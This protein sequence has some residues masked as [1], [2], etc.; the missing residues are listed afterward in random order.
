MARGLGIYGEDKG[1]LRGVPAED[2][3]DDHAQEYHRV[4]TSRSD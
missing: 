1:I 2:Y 3:V 4:R